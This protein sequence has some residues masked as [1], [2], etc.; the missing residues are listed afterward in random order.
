MLKKTTNLSG[1]YGELGR[2]PFIIQRKFNMIKYWVKL[3]KSS[4]TSL[5]KRIYTMLKE[6]ADSGN[7]Y[8]GSN[9]ASHIKSMLNN[10]GF[11]YIWLH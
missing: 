8:N 9:W 3:L 7:T 11:S 5:P 2:V 10:L 1:M 6:D 4:D